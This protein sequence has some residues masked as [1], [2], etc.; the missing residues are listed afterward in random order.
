MIDHGSYTH[1]LNSCEIKA[2]KKKPR[3]ILNLFHNCLSCAH[4][5]DDQS[6]LHIFLAV[7]NNYMIF[8]N[9]HL[10]SLPSMVI[11][12]T[13]KVTSSQMAWYS[14]GGR[15]LYWYR[16]GHG[17]ESCSGMNFF[18]ALIS[19]LLKLWVINHVFISFFTVE[20]YDLSYIFL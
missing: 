15:A 14:S 8:H 5:C 9:I 18:Q 4:N 11:L 7:Q 1:N 19:Q 10:Y 20:I 16:R 13:H 6:C 12:W 17:F 3:L 2:W